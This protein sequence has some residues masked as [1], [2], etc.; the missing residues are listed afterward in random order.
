MQGSS[1]DIIMTAENVPGNSK[2]FV[3]S[4]VVYRRL[5]GVDIISLANTKTHQ[6]KSFP[7]QVFLLSSCQLQQLLIKSKTLVSSLS[8][9]KLSCAVNQ[10]WR[11]SPKML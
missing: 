8:S 4:Q 10:K 7:Y 1:I 2:R 11:T 3:L 9:L 6:K 5:E